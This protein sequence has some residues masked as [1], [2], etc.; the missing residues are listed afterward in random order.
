MTNWKKK[1]FEWKKLNKPKGKKSQGL[2]IPVTK[3][4]K[5]MQILL[6]KMSV[7]LQRENKFLCTLLVLVGHVSI[8]VISYNGKCGRNCLPNIRFLFFLSNE[9]LIFSCA[10]K[11]SRA[12]WYKDH[13]SRLPCKKAEQLG[14][15][16]WNGSRIVTF[17][18]KTG[19]LTLVL[20]L[21]FSCWW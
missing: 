19:T 17:R 8:S 2:S 14:S 18:R 15:G 13:I 10:K 1:I 21:P 20:A 6:Q 5:N 7:L 4:S 12:T 3:Q 9:L 11:W 16:Q